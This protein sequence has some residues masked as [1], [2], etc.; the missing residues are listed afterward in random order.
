MARDRLTTSAYAVMGLL[1]RAPAAGYELGT[2]AA[3]TI[4]N[5]WPLTRTHIYT[6]L[7]RLESAGLV[8]ST[9]VAQDSRPDKRVY[10]VTDDGRTAL[11]QWLNDPEVPAER[12]RIPMLVKLFFGQRMRPERRTA[13]LD[14]YRARAQAERD[15]F[16][17]IVDELGHQRPDDLYPRITAMYGM[18]QLDAMLAWL[19]EVQSLVGGSTEKPSGP[20]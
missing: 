4:A 3:R 5:F 20:Q 8:A 12:N 7:G 18:R 14:T 6:E 19:S 15:A 10:E 9:A 2:V 16:A 1:D 13:L 11:D 17:A